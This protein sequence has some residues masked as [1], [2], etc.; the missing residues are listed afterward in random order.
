MDDIISRVLTTEAYMKEYMGVDPAKF[1]DIRH[2][3]ERVISL[4]TDDDDGPGSTHHE[5]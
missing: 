5:H 3:R 4:E 1:E 2:H